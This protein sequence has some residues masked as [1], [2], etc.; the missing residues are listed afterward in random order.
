[1]AFQWYTFL[2]LNPVWNIVNSFSELQRSLAAMERV[3]EVL[4]ME[5]DKPDRPDAREAGRRGI[6]QTQAGAGDFVRHFQSDP[7][8]GERLVVDLMTLNPVTVHKDKLAVE[9]LNLLERHRIDDLVVIDDDNVPVGVVDS[10]DL[11]RL[12]LL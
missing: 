6:A 5:H 8:I 3:F 10:Q 4:A 7:R 11:T 2:L 9:V 12:K 1:M